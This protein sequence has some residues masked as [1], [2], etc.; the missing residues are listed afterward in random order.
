MFCACVT[1]LFLSGEHWSLVQRYFSH[2]FVAFRCSQFRFSFVCFVISDCFITFSVV[3]YYQQSLHQIRTSKTFFG[4]IVEQHVTS[5][6]A[7][8]TGT[9]FTLAYSTCHG[10][11]WAGGGGGGK[12]A[13]DS[14]LRH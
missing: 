9:Y 8:V 14:L 13:A 3:K 11:P 6:A 2:V 10:G 4:L 1:P 5:Q 7:Y 12:A